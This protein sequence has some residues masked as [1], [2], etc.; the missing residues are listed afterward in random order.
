MRPTAKGASC[1]IE[2]RIRSPFGGGYGGPS[3][4]GCCPFFFFA[5]FLVTLYGVWIVY[6]NTG[7]E[8]GRKSPF[9][10][11]RLIPRHI[12][13]TLLGWGS[14][15]RSTRRAREPLCKCTLAAS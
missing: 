7:G 9:R 12:L 10:Y 4:G 8:Y 5:S 6:G 1:Y 11:E 14:T 2:Q 3:F 15:P 13:G